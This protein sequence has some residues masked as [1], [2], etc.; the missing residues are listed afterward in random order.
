MKLCCSFGEI[1][2]QISSAPNAD[3]NKQTFLI[4]K[5]SLLESE[6]LP[7]KLFPRHRCAVSHIRLL[8]DAHPRGRIQG[9]LVGSNTCGQSSP[10]TAVRGG[11]G[12][13]EWDRYLFWRQKRAKGGISFHQGGKIWHICIPGWTEQSG[14]ERRSASDGAEAWKPPQHNVALQVAHSKHIWYVHFSD[15]LRLLFCQHNNNVGCF[16]FSTA[17]Y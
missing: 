2:N 14:W 13:G 1:H 6:N 4:R 3:S 10:Q 12:H 8:E 9:H 17:L 5:Q 16:C 11:A 7:V 15:W